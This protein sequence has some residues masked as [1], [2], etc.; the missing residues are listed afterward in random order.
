M[1]YHRIR[2]SSKKRKLHFLV[3]HSEILVIYLPPPM[4]LHL[5]ILRHSIM[6]VLIGRSP[7]LTFDFLRSE[8]NIIL[9]K[10]FSRFFIHESSV[11][12]KMLAASRHKS[13][14]SLPERK[15]LIS[16]PSMSQR[17]R[18]FLKVP[19]FTSP[20]LLFNSNPDLPKQQ[21]TTYLSFPISLGQSLGS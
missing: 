13:A 18:S 19:Y 20:P 11:P 21:K 16:I 10:K 8:K 7:V 6:T 9:L 12:C 1:E 15:K 3:E 14:L 5:G 2:N 17:I 4:V